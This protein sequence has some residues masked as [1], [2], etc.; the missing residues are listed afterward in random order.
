MA[1]LW[2]QIPARGNFGLNL[3]GHDI[4]DVMD[5]LL[6]RLGKTSVAGVVYQRTPGRGDAP[7]ARAG[8]E[9]ATQ[10]ASSFLSS[11]CGDRLQPALAGGGFET[12]SKCSRRH[13]TPS[14]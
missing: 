5:I 14:L 13:L 3:P 9:L 1:S 11:A 7:V 4:V 10:D 2:T 8:C 6:F 12:H